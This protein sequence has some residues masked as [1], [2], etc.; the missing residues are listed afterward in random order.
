METE[1]AASVL[2]IK[3]LIPSVIKLTDG[4]SMRG[5][6]AFQRSRRRDC[7]VDRQA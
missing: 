2:L 3:I 6:A 5:R 1:H 7:C 4:C